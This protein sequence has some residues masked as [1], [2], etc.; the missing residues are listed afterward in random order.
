MLSQTQQRTMNLSESKQHPFWTIIA[1]LNSVDEERR[2]P[3]AV[4][5]TF[6]FSSGLLQDT[7]KR[8]CPAV[9]FSL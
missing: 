6:F 2:G 4:N 7:I 3:F 1:F 9:S 5:C 8:S